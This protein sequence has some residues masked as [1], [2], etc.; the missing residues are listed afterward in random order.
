M[1]TASR[2]LAGRLLSNRRG[3]AAVIVA[4]TLPALLVGVALA[5]ESAFIEVRNSQLQAAADAAAGGGRQSY[6]PFVS[7]P[8]NDVMVEAKRLADANLA[9]SLADADVVQGWWDI[10]DLKH[11]DKFGP[12]V[13]GQTGGAFSNAV[14]VTTREDHVIAM[15]AL[16]GRDRI[17][18]SRQST[19]YKCSNLDYPLSRIPD[20]PNPPDKPAIWLSY[21]TIAGTDDNTSYYYDNPISNHR[22]PVIKFWSPTDGED[23]SYVI[24]V[25]DRNGK[26]VGTMQADT[27]CRGTYLVI[28]DAF[29]WS[30]A[31]GPLTATIHRGSTN[32][33]VDTYPDDDKLY[34][35]AFRSTSYYL[36]ADHN[37]SIDG[38]L[39]NRSLVKTTRY[40]NASG[41]DQY[42]ASVGDPTP[43]RRSL[44]VR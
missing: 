31:A 27:Y 7:G 18:L 36:D 5:V 28:P 30:N 37:V 17:A 24:A 23:V 14:R 22:E 19:G 34:P 12:P 39:L 2:A 16:L 9:G 32:N 33:S 43:D 44:I 26:G 29:D 8:Q 41:I 20:D 42:W 11:D 15:G 1:L 6:N 4:V 10:T 3:A 21:K 38:T 40:P 25:V 13:G 35:L